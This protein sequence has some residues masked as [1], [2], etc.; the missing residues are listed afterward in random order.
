MS[1]L[2]LLSD[3]SGEPPCVLSRESLHRYIDSL[4]NGLLDQDEGASEDITI[5]VNLT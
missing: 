3:E 2:F 1:E 5:H 4:L